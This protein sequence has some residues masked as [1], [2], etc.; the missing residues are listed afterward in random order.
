MELMEDVIDER[1]LQRFKA[2]GRTMANTMRKSIMDDQGF[3]TLKNKVLDLITNLRLE[4]QILNDEKTA[5]RSLR[6]SIKS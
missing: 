4:K 6:A 2:I 5:E 1:Q 3:S